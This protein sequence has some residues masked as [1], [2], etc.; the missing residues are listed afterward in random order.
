MS[1]LASLMQNAP[2]SAAFMMGQNNTQTRQSEAL[3]QQELQQIIAQKLQQ[4]KQSEAMNPLLMEHQNLANQGLQAG[5]PGITAD[6]ALKGQSAQRGAATMDS[7]I[8]AHLDKNDTEKFNNSIK[9]SKAIGE[10]F[11]RLGPELSNIPDA[12]GQRHAHILS[13]MKSF[14]LKESD[15]QVQ[16]MLQMTSNIPSSNLPETLSAVGRKLVEQSSK[17]IE[18]MDKQNAANASHEKVAAGNNAATI[19]AA[20]IGADSRRDV[21]GIRKGQ[22]GALDALLKA[23]NYS[24]AAAVASAMAMSEEDPDRKAQL[25]QYSQ[26]MAAQ[27]LA[28]KQAGASAPGKVDAAALSGLPQAQTNNPMANQGG[29]APAAPMLSNAGQ[30]QVA[31]PGAVAKLRTNPGLAAAFDAKYGPGAAKKALGQ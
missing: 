26:M 10:E 31:P 21:A 16:R 15:P 14:G 22:A 28:S 4:M 25:Q 1:D 8:A 27:D 3:R 29:G 18:E 19:Q 9:K 17:Y 20:Q 6:S 12:L 2:G 24:G 5:L 11:L 30:A 7:D 23:R 13:A